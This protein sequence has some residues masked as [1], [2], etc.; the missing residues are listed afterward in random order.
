MGLLSRPW[1]DRTRNLGTPWRFRWFWQLRRLHEHCTRIPTTLA[2]SKNRWRRADW[3]DRL[4]TI[5]GEYLLKPGLLFF[6][7]YGYFL[8]PVCLFRARKRRTPAP[9]LMLLLCGAQL[10]A[11]MTITF[12]VAD[13]RYE[14]NAYLERGV[15]HIIP[16]A[17]VTCAIGTLRD[18]DDPRRLLNLAK[19]AR[20]E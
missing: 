20:L 16:V 10:T 2:T 19:A 8:I 18:E 17:I 5:I 1:A 14:L 15:A 6:W 11:Y 3:S 4:A 12:L 7:L 9:T 13:I